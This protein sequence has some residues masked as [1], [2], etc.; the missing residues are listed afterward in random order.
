MLYV[1]GQERMREKT[2]TRDC[3]H[4]Q[5]KGQRHEKPRTTKSDEGDEHEDSDN[6]HERK[7]EERSP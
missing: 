3:S 4:H 6:A 2:N 5:A 1:N 7:N